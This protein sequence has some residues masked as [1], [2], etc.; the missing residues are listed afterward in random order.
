M[1]NIEIKPEHIYNV[2]SQPVNGVA[3]LLH[4]LS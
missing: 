2:N 1:E 3:A 4:I